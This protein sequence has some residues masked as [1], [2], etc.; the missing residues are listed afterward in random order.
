VSWVIVSVSSFLLT[1]QTQQ[2]AADDEG[3]K[4]SFLSSITKLTKIHL[5]L[6]PSNLSLSS[7]L[8]LTRFF[9]PFRRVARH[10][11]EP[12]NIQ[13]TVTLLRIEIDCHFKGYRQNRKTGGELQK[14]EEG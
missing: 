12:C 9:S 8:R 7:P 1:L 3:D 4:K 2:K 6:S 14:G 10:I 13:V 11:L 5:Y